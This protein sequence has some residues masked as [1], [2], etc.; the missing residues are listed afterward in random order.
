MERMERVERPKPIKMS[1]FSAR[2]A[3]LEQMPSSRGP[4]VREMERPRT[5]SYG[6]L[7]RRA[8][9]GFRVR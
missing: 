4:F 5:E 1:E 3:G 7:F 2:V 6:E 8:N 9:S